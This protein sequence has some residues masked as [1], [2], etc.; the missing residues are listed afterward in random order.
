MGPEFLAAAQAAAPYL[1]VGGAAANYLGEQQANRE[2][3]GILN[4]AM[5]QTNEAQDKATE[6][7]QDE[8]KNYAPD[9]RLKDM[10]AQEQAAYERAQQDTGGAVLE[11]A[12]GNVSDAYVRAK[13][14]KAI[15][16]GDRLSKIAREMARVRAPGLQMHNEGL[17]LADLAGRTG[18]MFGSARNMAQAAQLDAQAV[19]APWWGQL[20]KLA[21]AVGSGLMLGAGA[22]T[23]GEGLLLPGEA[24]A[25]AGVWDKSM[26]RA[27]R[28]RFG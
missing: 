4:R 16:E 23:A 3:R 10:Q 28:I 22:E 2:R 12:K 6:L 14:D 18:S 21:Q 19:D 27:P 11:D 13:A 9:Q 7:V 5:A 25:G 24:S 8:A 26:R 17:G 20:G 1:A 15:Q